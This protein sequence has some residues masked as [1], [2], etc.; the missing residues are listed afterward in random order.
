M[1]HKLEKYIPLVEFIASCN[2]NFEVILHDTNNPQ[3]S[4]IAICN[5]HLSGRKI[6]DSMTDLALNVMKN[7]KHTNVDFITNYEG[8]LKNGKVFISSTYFIKEEGELIGMLCINH[9]PSA[10]IEMKAQINYLLDAFH[11]PSE[12]VRPSYTELLDSSITNL[13]DSL[14]QSTVHNF[15][16]SP[17]R[18][19]SDEKFAIVKSL[20]EQ[21]VFT[22]KGALPQVAK[23]LKISE[24]TVYRYLKKIRTSK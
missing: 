11:V 24:P 3:H 14:I 23:E 4:V 2:K 20:N 12:E 21:D 10:L 5:G 6:G 1:S 9:D 19:T 16:V 22:T 18:M 8:R 13:A 15:G 17:S 7:R